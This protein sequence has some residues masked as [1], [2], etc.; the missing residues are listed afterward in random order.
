[1]KLH[2]R[3]GSVYLIEDNKLTRLSET[4]VYSY[5][6]QEYDPSL[7]FNGVE[8]LDMDTPIL[9]Q[10]CLFNTAVGPINITHIERIES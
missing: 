9:G 4:P 2:T 10:R 1:M 7:I 5:R 6:K 8:I 3:S